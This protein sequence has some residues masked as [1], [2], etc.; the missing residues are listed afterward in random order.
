MLVALLAIGGLL[1]IVYWLLIAMWL[2]QAAVS[3]SINGVVWL[4]LE[5]LLN[6]CA[7]IAFFIIRSTRAACLVCG[8]RQDKSGYCRFCGSKI[9]VLCGNCGAD[10]HILNAYVTIVGQALKATKIK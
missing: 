8:K 2:Y 9:Q 5:I 4:I 3:V 10:I 7:V 6:L 1:G